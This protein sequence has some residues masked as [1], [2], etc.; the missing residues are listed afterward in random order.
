MRNIGKENHIHL[1]DKLLLRLCLFCTKHSLL[2]R[3]YTPHGSYKEGQDSNPR[4]QI[5]SICPPC[6]PRSRMYN[7]PNSIFSYDSTLIILSN[8]NPKSISSSRKICIIGFFIVMSVN[9]I[10]VESIQFIIM[11][12]TF[13]FTIV[14]CGKRDTETIL[15]VLQINIR[16]IR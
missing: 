1:I 8:P 3:A 6:S 15:I 4:Y 13:T 11:V 16:I 7:N 12:Q 5:K 10:L 14:E 2:L 9:P